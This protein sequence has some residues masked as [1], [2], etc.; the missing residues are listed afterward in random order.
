MAKE[1]FINL[2]DWFSFALI[3]GHFIS[4][5]S[6]STGWKEMHQGEFKKNKI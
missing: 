4:E 2:P 1:N 3:S 5:S 6:Y